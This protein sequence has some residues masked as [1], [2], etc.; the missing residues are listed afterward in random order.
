VEEEAS[1]C[2]RCLL[3]SNYPRVSF[4][5]EGVCSYCRAY[6]NRWKDWKASDS[7]SE[8][9]KIVESAKKR[10]PKYSAL[11]GITGGKD[12]TYT[13]HL[14]VKRYGLNVLT[15]T[16]DNGF[17]TDGARENIDKIVKKLNVRHRYVSLDRDVE[18]RMYRALFKRRCADFCQICMLGVLAGGNYLALKENVPMVVWGVSPRTDPVTPLELFLGNDYRYLLDVVEPEVN[19]SEFPLFENTDILRI[20]HIMFAKRVRLVF[21]PQYV[22]WDEKEI[23]ELIQKEYGW[24]DYGGGTPHFDCVANDAVD[25]FNMQR[26]GFSKVVEKLSQLVRSGQITREEAL[27][28]YQAQEQTVEPVDSVNEVCRRLG[29]GREALKYLLDGKSLD[30]RHFKSYSRLIERFSW[31]LWIT[32]KLGLTTESLYRKYSW[33]RK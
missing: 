11:V 2:T 33:K 19:R 14:L 5:A 22:R 15:F 3:P 25:Y 17:F 29:V 12:S 16:Y 13:L 21:L 1:R 30:Y 6:E 20:L 18:Q 27:E 24:T 9:L 7:E 28:K 31:L 23:S 26:F 10:N 8:L 4:D 32:S